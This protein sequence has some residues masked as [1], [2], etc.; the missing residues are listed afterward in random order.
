MVSFPI[1]INFIKS[2]SCW[3]EGVTPH[4]LDCVVKGMLKLPRVSNLL[5]PKSDQYPISPYNVTPESN[6]NVTRKKEML[7]N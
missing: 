1:C 2:F 4:N 6:I 7:T 3:S 5:T